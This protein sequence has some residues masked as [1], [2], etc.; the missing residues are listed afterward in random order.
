MIDQETNRAA[1]EQVAIGLKE[2][3]DTAVFV[4]GAVVSL[5]ADDP[6]ISEIRMTEDIDVTLEVNKYS[7]YVALEEKLQQKK[8]YPDPESTSIV[9]HIYNGIPVDIIPNGA[10]ISVSG[11]NKWYAYG[12]NDVRYVQINS[13]KIRV[14]SPAVFLATKLEAFKNRGVDYRTSHD[15][16]DVLYIIEN[17]SGIVLDISKAHKDV[18][19]FIKEQFTLL[20][21]QQSSEEI[22]SANIDRAIL[23]EMLPI[24][25]ERI[26]AII[27]GDS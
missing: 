9:R 16:E 3:N 7:D 13:Q 20:L 25:K 10:E 24:L 22:L 14:Y 15:I 23:E 8:F 19:T 4:G 12:N 11:T 26:N 27:L 21:S 1:I 2:I 5:Y 6:S 17:N 18:R